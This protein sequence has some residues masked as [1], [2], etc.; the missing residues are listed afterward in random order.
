ML[1]VKRETETPNHLPDSVRFDK[2]HVEGINGILPFRQHTPRCQTAK[3]YARQA[4]QN[5]ACQ[6]S[7]W[8]MHQA[9]THFPK[10]CGLSLDLGHFLALGLDIPWAAVATLRKDVSVDKV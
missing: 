2:V 9:R 7:G 8:L 5:V 1:R 4:F 6:V 3:P 10:S